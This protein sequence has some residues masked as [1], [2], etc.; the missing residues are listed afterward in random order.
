MNLS[1]IS[2]KKP[3]GRMLRLPLKLIPP[4]TVIPIL[5]GSLKGKKWISGSGDHGCWLGSY[6]Y[7]KQR[8]FAELV[9][10]DDIVFDIGA[11]VGFYTLLASTLVG[12]GRVVAFEPVPE[13]LNHLRKHLS[14]NRVQ[15]VTVLEAAVS[16][17]EETVLFKRG[18][19]STN[20]SVD[21]KGDLEVTAVTIDGLISRGEV[22]LP[23][24]IKMDIE[25]GEFLALIG[26]RDTLKEHHPVIFLA[27]HSTEIH[28]NCC[29]FLRSLG[30]DLRPVVG[31]DVDATD[32]IIAFYNNS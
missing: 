28:R 24:V 3:L 8:L 25:G 15:N 30:Y 20:G 23:S 5:Q 14:L 2:N 21:A 6:E 16:D 19:S 22:E 10:D 29:E 17:E 27:T 13:N 4:S 9:S 32:E 26:A 18:A 31:D 1:G 12:R 11:N 7:E